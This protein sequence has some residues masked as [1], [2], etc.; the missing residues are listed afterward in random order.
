[1]VRIN[2]AATAAVVALSAFSLGVP[3]AVADD[4]GQKN[5]RFTAGSPGVGDPYYPLAGNGGY[6]VTHYD[7][8]GR[9]DPATDVWA[10]TTTI[11]ATATADLY[12]FNLDFDGLGIASLSVNGTSAGWT[13]DGAELSVIPRVKIKD[14]A[15][16]EVVV[17]YSGVP[18]EYVIAGTPLPAGFMATDDG[19]NVAG[20]PEV[21]AAWFPVNDHPV[22]KA[23]YTFTITV[24]EDLEVVANGR[25][26]QATTE[27]GWETFTWD[28]TAPMASYLAT[29]DIGEWDIRQWTT[30]SG[31]PVYDAVDPDLL[32]GDNAELGASIDASLARQGEVLDVLAE[33]FGA[34]PFDTVG[35]IVDD[36]NDLLFALETQTRPVYSKYFWPDSGDFV[37][38]HELAHQ[39][40]GDDVALAR[41]QDIWL[42]EG[43]ATY[44]E[45]IWGE[46][47]G[48][49]TAQDVFDEVMGPTGIPADDPFWSVVIGA[50]TVDHL[51]DFAVYLRGG[52]T[53]Q[54][55]RQEAGDEDFWAIVETWAHENSGGHGTTPE[56]IDLAEEVS[57]LDL[58]DLFDEWLFT[59]GRPDSAAAAA[60]STTRSAATGVERAQSLE[61]AS[62]REGARQRSKQAGR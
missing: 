46:H 4:S 37:V 47:E 26:V 50:P 29:I 24:P 51:F 40:Y 42:N 41:W 48:F 33:H 21:A 23:S 32:T 53:L 5:G 59:P 31:L 45:W 11:Q 2:R 35:A 10:A 16:M 27:S 36:Q 9:Y 49:F 12:R 20:Q 60:A 6:D 39:W 55:L 17:R 54:A 44:A 28:A 57:G 19:A 38:V 34:Y 22:D 13:R 1:M 3:L 43:F 30:N 14:G 8:V 15:A 58:D 62:W 25:L 56:F 61:A 52:L 7:I 18:I